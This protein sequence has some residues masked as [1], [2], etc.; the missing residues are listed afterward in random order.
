M[1]LT[2]FLQ[3]KLTSAGATDERQ[4]IMMYMMPI[5]FVFIFMRLSSGLILYYTV[6]NILSIGQQYLINLKDKKNNSLSPKALSR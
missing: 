3:Q 6:F 2:M 1:G 5:V 4:K